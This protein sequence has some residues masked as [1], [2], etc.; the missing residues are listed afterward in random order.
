[1]VTV[2]PLTE[3]APAFISTSDPTELWL[4]PTF[5]TIDPADDTVL[6][7]V[8]TRTAPDGPVDEG[9]V[10]KEM[11]PVA[12]VRISEPETDT[13]PSIDFPLPVDKNNEPPVEP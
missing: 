6:E 8:E 4:P 1:M 13:S 10:T 5:I 12:E 9:S 2:P 3:P 7:P 11:S